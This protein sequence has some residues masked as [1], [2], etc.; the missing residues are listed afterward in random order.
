MSDTP[1]LKVPFI[2][3]NISVHDIDQEGRGVARY[4]DIVVFVEKAIPGD[5]VNA[6][7]FKKK[8]RFWEA[9][10]HEL[11][12]P[13]PL[14][15]TPFC[16]H[17]GKC[18]GCQWQQL[19][20]SGQLEYKARSVREALTRIGNLEFPE[21]KPIVPAL[22]TTAYRNKL[23]FSFS[24][25]SWVSKEEL[26][27]GLPDAPGLGFH[28]KGVFDK[29][30][31]ISECHLMPEVVNEIRNAVRDFSQE[32]NYEYYHLKNHTGWLRNLVIRQ[33]HA[34]GKIMVIL[35][36]AARDEAKLS[37][38]FTL[39]QNRFPQ[40]SSCIWFLN[41]KLNDS[42]QGLEPIVWG[43]TDPYLVEKLGN[44]Q[45]RV[46]PRSFFQTN[47]QQAER[48]YQLVYDAIGE[49]VKVI[50]DLYCGAG[51]IGI[52]VS[53][54]AEKIVGVEY[55]EDAVKDAEEN[56]R[57]NNLKHLNFYSGD[58][59]K[60]MNGSLLRREGRPQVIITDPP[61]AGM[62]AAVVAEL[63][64][65]E[66]DKIIYVSCNPA[67]QARDLALMNDAY[68]I[69]SVQPVDMFPHTTHVECVVV[70]ERRGM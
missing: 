7:V 34:S 5:V 50:Y 38:L 47:T 11:I 49:P 30:L 13:S 43:K 69:V 70:L 33:S 36:V 22:S 48:L 37:A 67:T 66:A 17:F 8:S 10:L 61:R 18:G 6:R 31:P 20:Y 25:R 14:R 40:I 65:T 53:D 55:I 16:Q 64:K 29:V 35:S 59:K 23:D 28:L 62:D 52:F 54:K 3:E 32:N 45:F 44:Y 57:L 12:Q 2:A 60:L 26:N 9:A 39:L 21:L 68:K 56:C 42:F 41:E 63:I 1:V 24:A 46:S 19:Q 27:I 58:M 15:T 51:S 4:N